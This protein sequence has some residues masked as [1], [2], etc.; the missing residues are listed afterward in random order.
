ML[1]WIVGVAALAFMCQPAT[2]TAVPLPPIPPSRVVDLL[3][4][5]D[6]NTLVVQQDDPP[7]PVDL[8]NVNE[9][10]CTTYLISELVTPRLVLHVVDTEPRV[11]ADVVNAHDEWLNDALRSRC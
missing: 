5:A 8:L 6:G 10:P 11:T 1:L 4:V 3:H 2:P 7:Y 9:D